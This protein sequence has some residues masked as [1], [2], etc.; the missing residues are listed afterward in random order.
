[1]SKIKHYG[2]K[3]PFTTN[4]SEGTLIDLSLSKREKVI[5]EMMHVLFTPKGERLRM[6]NFGTSLIQYIFNPDDNQTWGDVISEI[7]TSIKT[8]I[9]DCNIKNIEITEGEQEY[10]LYAKITYTVAEGG[11]ET[12][13][14][15]ITK[16]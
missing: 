12:E 7:K 2:I 5:S 15:T 1:M 9:P 10:E 13:Y 4:G 11:Y 6:P 16:L 8:Y 14:Q 3:F